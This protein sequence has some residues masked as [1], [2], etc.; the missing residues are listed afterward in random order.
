MNR[1]PPRFTRPDTLF[2][3]TTLFRSLGAHVALGR[4]AEVARQGE[5]AA[6][7]ARAVVV[8]GGRHA[9]AGQ[10][11]EQRRLVARELRA[12]FQ[13]G[14]RE[15]AA[16]APGGHRVAGTRL[17]AGAGAGQRPLLL[18]RPPSC[19]AAAPPEGACPQRLDGAAATA[20]AAGEAR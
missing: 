7:L 8:S 13:I 17:A 14:D 1:P 11:R 5:E 20:R 16:G 9:A 12:A 15:P 10:Q 19:C 2:P 18:D 4:N 6:V 3:Y